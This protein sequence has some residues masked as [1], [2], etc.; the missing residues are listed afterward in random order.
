MGGW[1]AA[2]DA[3]GVEDPAL[4]A[5]YTR[6][7]ETSARF[8]RSAHLAARL[9]LPREL[10]AHV[11]AATAF[12]HHGDNL[13]D[14]GAAPERAAA[15]GRWERE[16]RAGL[17]TGA[18]EDPVVRPLLHTITAH[19]PLRGY[20]EA[21][22]DTARTD[23]DFTGFATEADYQDY[24]DRYS[25]PAFMLVACLLAPR[26]DTPDG[27]RAAAYRAACRTYI[28]AAQRLDFANDLAEDLAGGRLALPLET[29]ARFGVTREELENAR[30]TDGTRQLLRHV[31]DRAGATLEAARVLDGLAAPA[32]RPLVRALIDIEALTA[33]AARAKGTGL[34]HGSVGPS[35][36]AAVR[37]LLREYVRARRGR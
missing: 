34:L 2:L 30:D 31:L 20:A 9:L 7:R 32:G 14:S 27:G 35:G 18:S 11:V 24:V 26:E 8:R 6:A 19:P 17:D 12:M 3:A 4:R 29:L 37:V 36:V 1:K 5:D 10:F 15:Y 33:E 21:Y 28:D 22:L 23:L 25:L 13:L 16:V